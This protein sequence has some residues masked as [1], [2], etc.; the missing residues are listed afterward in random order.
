[1]AHLTTYDRMR[2]VF[3]HRETD[4]IPIMDSPW[5]S[6][7]ERWRREGMPT[8]D[9]VSYFGLDHLYNIACDNS[10]RLPPQTLEETEDYVVVKT[11]WGAT[12]KDWKHAASAPEFLDFVVTD[13]DSWRE[14]KPRMAPS[15]ERVNW[16]HLEQTYR[17]C[18][19]RG[20]WVVGGLWF[21]FD[22]THAWM[23]GTERALMA[24]A[25]D[26]EWLVD[27]WTAQLELHLALF[28]MIL[29]AGYEIDSVF[30]PD[31][32]GYK[33]SQFFSADTYGDLLQPVHEKAAYWA[34]Y[35]GIKT[36]LHSCGDVNPLIPHLIE[37]GIDCLN[38]LE[39][40]AG[41]D[42]VAL[43]RRYGDQLAF[44]GGINAV[45]WDQP[46]AIE[47]E[48]RE[49]IPV[50]KEGGGYIFSSDHSV[51]DA[52]SLEDFRR[53]TDLAKELGAYA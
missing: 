50:M 17:A 51:P 30:W 45:L 26:P 9:Y 36:H 22:V 48:M 20:D 49:V 52:V 31:D 18:R 6:T 32:M 37:A 46:E 53:I 38:P 7:I 28:D 27:I 35:R 12:L 1:M 19:E 29:D 43:K 41:M 3:E 16:A 2:G 47:A 23:V 44:H 4:R 42:P 21:G 25:T 40:K 5:R 24:L 11:P 13:W 33:G 34:H 15:S 10:P 14:V 39:V 8:D